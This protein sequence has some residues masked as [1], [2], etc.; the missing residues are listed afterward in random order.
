MDLG[1]GTSK[2]P[3]TLQV[4]VYASLGL[5]LSAYL[6]WNYF[7]PSSEKA[8]H[9]F[10]QSPSVRQNHM[11]LHGY[12]IAHMVVLFGVVLVAAGLEVGVHE[13]AH[14]VSVPGAWNLSLGIALYVLGIS[15]F[16]YVMGLA[17]SGYRAMVGLLA[18]A[19]AFIG[20]NRSALW[21]LAACV[22]ILVAVSLLENYLN[23]KTH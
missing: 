19:T 11:A 5:L 8:E 21:Q 12:S 2:Q 7:G 17:A 14:P 23:N 4:L 13:L 18:I 1:L 10:L 20:L 9:A 3:L 15:H 22:G 6:W 16:Y